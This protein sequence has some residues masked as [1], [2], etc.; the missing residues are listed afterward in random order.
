MQIP[1]DELC[2]KCG[3][4]LELSLY[5]ELVPHSC[6]ICRDGGRVRVTEGDRFHPMFGKTVLCQ[7]QQYDRRERP[8]WR[9]LV[10]GI[11]LKFAEV[12]FADWTP[13]TGR[14]RLAA[15][16]YVATWPPAKPFLTLVGPP[17][18]GKTM[19]ACC[20]LRAAYERHGCHGARY[21]VAEL[22]E[23]LRAT[24]DDQPV[25]ERATIVR[26][27]RATPLLVLDDIGQHQSTDWT[28]EQLFTSL[29]QRYEDGLPTVFTC[30]EAGWNALRDALRSR[31]SEGEV[32]RLTGPDRRVQ[33]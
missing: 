22:L 21:V 28:D 7:C 6:C 1:D 5:G 10:R 23:R 24:M 29:N 27:L 14:A 18:T 11:P 12:K 19:L 33:R 30:N 17:G 25:E 26:S 20:I 2:P 8:H 31:L 32:V 9:S 16:S 15:Q 4:M 3:A 13:D